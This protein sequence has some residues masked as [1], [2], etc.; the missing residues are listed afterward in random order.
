MVDIV[1]GLILCAGRGSRLRPYTYSRPKP[2]LLVGNKPVIEHAI[3]KLYDVGIR[4]IGIVVSPHYLSQFQELLGFEYGG[5]KLCY[6]EQ[7][8]PKGLAH[9]IQSARSFVQDAPF[10]VFLGDNYYSGDLISLV[11]RFQAQNHDA[12]VLTSVVKDPRQ[13][14]VA[15]IE[16][17]KVVKVVEKPTTPISSYALIGIYA[18][19]VRI[20]DAIEEL[21]PSARGE[22]EL[23]DAIQ[24]LIDTGG[25]VSAVV[26]TKWWKD[27][28]SPNDLIACNRHV[29]MELRE[30]DGLL[31]STVQTSV[32]DGPI[33]FGPGVEIIDSTVRGPAVIGA[34]SRIIRS[35]VGP[36]TSIGHDVRIEESEIE[37]SIVLERTTIL[38]IPQR[39]DDSI[40][41]GNVILERASRK[42]RNLQVR[43][44]DHSQLSL[45]FHLE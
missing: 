2:L 12:V 43:I 27:T 1:R 42:L 3:T 35:F 5:A 19:S 18:F 38:R 4:E 29:L 37:N 15:Q 33:V 23:T 45:P 44:G 28:G 34:N 31:H 11:D 40:I 30:T 39:I 6:I 7:R 21:K 16:D 22:Y 24:K 20:F 14:G 25:N 13:F 26:T 32:I 17:S 10:L 9:A 8:E 41:G 36:F